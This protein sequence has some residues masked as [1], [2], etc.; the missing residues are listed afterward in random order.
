MLLSFSVENWKS[1]KEPS[2][3]S[4]IASRERHHRETLAK[5][6]GN[7]QL[8]ILPVAAVF[9]ANASGKTSFFEALTFAREYILTG[10]LPDA[11]IPVIPF[12]LDGQSLHAPTTFSFVIQV[13]NQIISTRNPMR[14][15]IFRYE[16]SVTRQRVHA[17]SLTRIGTLSEFP[18]FSRTDNKLEL[19]SKFSDEEDRRLQFVYEGTRDEQLFL[20]NAISQNVTTFSPIYNWFKHTLNLVGTTT[21]FMNFN[22]CK[23]Q[24]GFQ[25]FISE[26]LNQLDTGIAEICFT[27]ISPDLLPPGINLNTLNLKDGDMWQIRLD[28]EGGTILLLEQRNSEITLQKMQTVHRSASGQEVRFDLA[29]ESEGTRRLIELLPLFF[30]LSV[31]LQ[32]HGQAVYVIDEL[33]KSLHSLVVKELITHF[34]DTCSA[35]SR[36]QLLFTTHDLLTMDQKLLRRDEIYIVERNAHGESSLAALCD[37]EN[38]RYDRNLLKSYLEGRFGGIPFCR[39]PHDA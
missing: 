26:S 6:Q 9:G 28:G 2:E 36:R 37:Y 18:V 22:L 32:N 33:D 1:Y 14:G 34:I 19:S 11:E 21:H 12:R 17:E 27:P 8:S 20:T 23:T 38:L 25:D 39:E 7:S 13:E 29:D 15:T 10:V 16:F 24:Q 3:I 4:M 5:P 35:D 31:A 30:D